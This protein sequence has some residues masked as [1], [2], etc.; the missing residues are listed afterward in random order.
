M[1]HIRFLVRN[2]FPAQLFDVLMSQPLVGQRAQSARDVEA[3][4]RRWQAGQVRQDCDECSMVPSKAEMVINS[5][6]DISV[7]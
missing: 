1:P 6:R 2:Y 3:E 4:T 5:S 7:P